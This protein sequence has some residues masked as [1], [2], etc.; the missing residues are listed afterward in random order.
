M[1]TLRRYCLPALIVL[2]GC[3]HHPSPATP[4]PATGHSG[5]LGSFMDDYEITYQISDSLWQLGSRDRYRIVTWNDSARYLVARNMEGNVAEAGKWTRIGWV[6]LPEMLPYQWA[7]CMTEYKGDTRAAAEANRS[8]DGT[9]PR[10]G[11]HGFPYSRMRRLPAD[12]V[13]SKPYQ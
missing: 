10:K 11:C 13:E 2:M 4:S 3:A 9:N 7:Y 1:H 6:E 12:S 8:A 5:L